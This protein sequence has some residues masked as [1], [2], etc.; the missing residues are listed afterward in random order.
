M[1]K[2]FLVAVVAVLGLASVGC[3]SDDNS[4]SNFDTAIQGVWKE[5]RT[6]YLDKNDKV[7]DEDEAYDEGCGLNELEFKGKD[8]IS[9]SFFM[10]ETGCDK[11]ELKITYSIKGNMLYS[12]ETKES[13][14][15]IELTATKLVIVGEIITDED[16]PIIGTFGKEVD[17]YENI[18]KVYFE[19]VRK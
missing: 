10:D 6:L 19:Y 5:S 16:M 11:E 17:P 4:S 1:R 7:I 13:T 3:S 18:K 14:E 8:L 15:I 2:L 9:R 12:N